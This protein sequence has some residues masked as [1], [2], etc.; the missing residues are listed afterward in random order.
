MAAAEPRPA[1]SSQRRPT[2]VAMQILKQRF[3]LS[4]HVAAHG[5]SLPTFLGTSLTAWAQV[6]QV[7]LRS[8]R[9]RFGIV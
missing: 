1:L 9:D 6:G 4:V 2:G 7:H 8:F 3:G 5:D